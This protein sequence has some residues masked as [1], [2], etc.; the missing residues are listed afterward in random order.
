[1]LKLYNQSLQIRSSKWTTRQRQ[2]LRNQNGLHNGYKRLH[3]ERKHKNIL[4]SD[5]FPK[6]SNICRL[7]SAQGSNN[8]I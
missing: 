7:K 6:F 2:K 4:Q 5:F 3:L 1:M 8:T